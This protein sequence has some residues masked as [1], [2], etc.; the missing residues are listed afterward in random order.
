MNI[1]VW[2]FAYLQINDTLNFLK[3]FQAST[4]RKARLS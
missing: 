2:F 3:W 4:A 1:E